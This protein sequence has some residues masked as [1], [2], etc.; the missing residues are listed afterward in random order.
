MT[1]LDSSID[2][3]ALE[4]DPDPIL[5]RLRD[6]APV[7]FAPTMEMWL[8]TRWDDVAFMD[9]HPE[10]FSAATEPSFLRRTLGVNML[11]LDAPEAARLKNAMM[12]PFQRSGTSGRF[13]ETE[14]PSMCDRFIDEL[15]RDGEMDVVSPYA[16][17]VSAASLQT[18][19]GISD[20][21]W[22]EVWRWCEGLCADISNFENDPEKRAL[23]DAAKRELEAA[24]DAKIDALADTTE[25]SAMA[26]MLAVDAGGKRLTR[27]EI[28]NN[29]RLMISGGINEPRDGIGLATWV[30]LAEPGL[31]EQVRSEPRLWRR[32]VDEVM[33]RFSP[34][35]TIT[36]QAT[37]DLELAGTR[38]K[39]G[40]LVAGVLRSAN[41]DER[42]WT[43]PERIDLGRAE[44]GHAAF[45]LGQHRCL[46]EWLGRQEVAVG[47]REALREAAG[48]SAG[49]GTRT[50]SSCVGFE[51]R[52]TEVAIRLRGMS[53]ESTA[54]PLEGFMFPRGAP[55]RRAAR[56][57]P[58]PAVA[59][60]GRAPHDRVPDRP[61]ACGRAASRPRSSPRTKTRGPSPSCGRTG[62][63]AP[64]PSRSCSTRPAPS[65]R[66]PSS[67]CA[68]SYRGE[69][70]SRCV[71]IWVDQDFALVRGYHQGYPKK[72][73]EI[74]MTRPVT[75]GRAG[76]RLEA[77]GRFGATV[78]AS[79]RRL[80][81]AELTLTGPSE[82]AGFVNGHPMIHHRFMPAI[83]SDGTDSLHELVTMRGFDLELGPAFRGDASIRLFDSPVE[84]LTRLEPVEMI[85]GY[86]RRV[87]TSWREGT[88]LDG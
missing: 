69:T 80:I 21:T 55:T 18:V 41:L 10:L 66:R 70:Y 9:E 23:G 13:A 59:L 39:K 29:V 81:D 58:P 3:G 74:W 46:G 25:D 71:Y 53:N 50:R 42:R 22:R 15:A 1:I 34:V 56:I 57:V 82:G 26:H 11:T 36:R 84:E 68:A 51:F 28:I 12:P 43:D 37:E 19:L 86:W 33:R 27:E 49:E 83:E 8:V 60:L 35:G 77:G 44:G 65:T 76:P 38:I 7:A 64:T 17:A 78:S 63:P 72:L 54:G 32:L 6:E 61:R 79:G 75:V 48:A 67:W 24:L 5:K 31:L 73:G 45:A 40:D 20:T 87:G 2:L 88:T 16:A 85:G 14:L 4:R 62:S 52:G 47:D 30:L